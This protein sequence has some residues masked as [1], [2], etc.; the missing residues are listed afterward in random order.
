MP[1]GPGFFMNGGLPSVSVS[2]I[3]AFGSHGNDPPVELQ[4]I[5]QGFSTT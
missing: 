5:Y 1:F 3:Q 2:G 4:N